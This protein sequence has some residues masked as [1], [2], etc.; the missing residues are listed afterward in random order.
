MVKV[1]NEMKKYTDNVLRHKRVGR[2]KV[3]GR[4]A[5]AFSEHR[6][7]PVDHGKVLPP[8]ATSQPMGAAFAIAKK[9][10]TRNAEVARIGDRE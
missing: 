7:L 3:R 10:H 2:G 9:K 6:K 4:A 8:V 5:E 1:K